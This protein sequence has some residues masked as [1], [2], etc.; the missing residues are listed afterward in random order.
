MLLIEKSLKQVIATIIK[1]WFKEF[2]T[3]NVILCTFKNGFRYHK[4]F[5]SIT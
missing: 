3:H 4:V 1:C 2:K 5:V